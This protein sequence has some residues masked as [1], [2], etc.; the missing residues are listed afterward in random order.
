MQ[1]AG[2]TNFAQVASFAATTTTYNDT[3]L[4]AGTSYSYQVQASD[5]DGA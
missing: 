2:C 1:G 4:T 5:I 3:G